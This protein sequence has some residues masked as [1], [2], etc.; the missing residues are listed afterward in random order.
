MDF[1]HIGIF[2]VHRHFQI[3]LGEV[4]GIRFV[5]LAFQETYL[6][7][8]HL[9]DILVDIHIALVDFHKREFVVEIVVKED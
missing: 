4:V 7:Q 8:N 9:F 2:V 6:G 5:A 3:E 1:H